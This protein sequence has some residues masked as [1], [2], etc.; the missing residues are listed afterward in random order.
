MVLSL[1][2]LAGN[3]V[4]INEWLDMH[5]K[6]PSASIRAVYKIMLQSY[7]E[8][9]KLQD[10]TILHDDAGWKG[11][12]DKAEADVKRALHRIE[13]HFRKHNVPQPWV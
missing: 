9:Q 5:L 6:N 13:T 10:V 4:P 11:N 3:T 7:G 8:I 1:Q 2:T 12:L